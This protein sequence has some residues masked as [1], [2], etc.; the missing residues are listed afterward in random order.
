MKLALAICGLILTSASAA[1]AS[2]NIFCRNADESVVLNLMTSRAYTLTVVRTVLTMGEEIWSD[3]PVVQPVKP[4]RSGQ[5]YENDGMLMVDFVAEAE[6]AVIARLKAFST[7][8]EDDFVSG[9]IFTVKGK[10]SWVVDC[11]DRG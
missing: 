7:V 5:A 2:G 9:G 11:S 8:G 1:S 3:D 6:G 10:G 4:I